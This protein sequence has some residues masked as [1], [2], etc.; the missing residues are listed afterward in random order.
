PAHRHFSSVPTRR[1]SDLGYRFQFYPDNV[2]SGWGETYEVAGA[3]TRFEDLPAREAELGD[4][5]PHLLHQGSVGE[6]RVECGRA[7][8]GH[9]L[10]RKSTRLNSSHV[11]I[12]Y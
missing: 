12:S 10:D 4:R 9:L 6:V 1:A 5:P 7:G 8:G 11:K 3:A 2:R